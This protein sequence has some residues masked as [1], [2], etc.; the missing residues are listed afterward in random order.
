MEEG[1][2]SK[3]SQT[4]KFRKSAL[5]YGAHLLRFWQERGEAA[6]QPVTWRFSLEN[7]H[8][9]E[10][11]GFADLEALLAHLKADFATNEPPDLW[12]GEHDH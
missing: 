10:R 11:K 4:Q 1:W 2:V 5:R 7:V 3:S 12:V 6:G 8:T 9:S